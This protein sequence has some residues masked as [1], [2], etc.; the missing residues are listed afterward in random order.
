M[1]EPIIT[2]LKVEPRIILH[3]VTVVLGGII[4]PRTNMSYCEPLCMSLKY[5][6]ASQ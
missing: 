2:G 6:R 4:L 1:A 5:T 3:K